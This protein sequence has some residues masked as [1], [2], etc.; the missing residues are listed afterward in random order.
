MEEVTRKRK[1]D[2]GTDGNLDLISDL[3]SHI[4][5]SILS[6]LP[7]RDAGRT[8]ALS[9]KW[10]GYWATVQHLD[11]GHQFYQTM[12]V[13]AGKKPYGYRQYQLKYEYERIIEKIFSLHRGPLVKV[14][15]YI[16][17]FDTRDN[18]IPDID[19]WIARL[20]GNNIKELTLTYENRERHLLPRCFFSCLDLTH[21]EL[22]NIVLKPPPDFKGFRSLVALK[23]IRV[24]FK[25]NMFESLMCGSPLLQKL[26][27]INS[28]GIDHFKVSA[29]NLES[30]CFQ[31]TSVFKTICFENVPKLTDVSISTMDTEADHSAKS[32]TLLEFLG[33]LPKLTRL[34]VNGKFLKFL[35]GDTLPQELPTAAEGLSY[36]KLNSLD[37]AN[38]DEISCALCLIRNTPNLK[39]LQIKACTTTAKPPKWGYMEV[40]DHFGCTL[41]GLRVV[42]MELI[43]G[44]KP[45]QELV[46]YL[47]S[48]SP[49]LGKM[50]IKYSQTQ[51][52]LI[53]DMATELIRCHKASP[54]VN[55]SLS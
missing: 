50:S 41:D 37:F 24:K 8:S 2:T 9:R 49:F 52:R 54:T 13:A 30:L 14:N 45:E 32:S 40:E 15:L 27:L 36:L 6:R 7:I 44:F 12:E 55:I 48:N 16:P 10:R 20:S 22:H 42:K 25:G 28:P 17:K 34:S 19:Q 38:F 3:P 46:Q 47:L 35:A 31:A 11:F 51:Q 4:I 21:L 53:L 29:P 43:K 26:I 39:E 23:F 33:S 18:R 1:L 5:N